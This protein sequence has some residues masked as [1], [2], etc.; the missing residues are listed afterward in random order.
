MRLTNAWVC[1]KVFLIIRLS[2]LR[3]GRAWEWGYKNFMADINVEL[4]NH[5][6]TD[7]T[8]DIVGRGQRPWC[9]L[10]LIWPEGSV[11]I[12]AQS[13]HGAWCRI[14]LDP[15]TWRQEVGGEG[16]Q[17]DK[18][19]CVLVSMATTFIEASLW[20]QLCLT[21]CTVSFWY[22]QCSVYHTE[23]LGMRLQNVLQHWVEYV[24]HKP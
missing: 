7:R 13:R 19:K 24:A 6:K 14:V 23:S 4:A 1:T 3:R 8:L 16:R 18:T 11:Q 12:Q 22:L 20:L 9:S 2:P 15:G 21:G 17:D 5:T 10:L